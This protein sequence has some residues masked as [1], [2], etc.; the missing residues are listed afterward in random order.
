[1]SIFEL[2]MHAPGMY[3]C[4][5]CAFFCHFLLVNFNFC[6]HSGSYFHY[7]YSSV[8]YYVWLIGQRS[9][10]WMDSQSWAQYWQ[11]RS[12]LSFKKSCETRGCGFVQMY[13]RFYFEMQMMILEISNHNLKLKIQFSEHYF[14]HDWW[15]F[16]RC[17]WIELFYS[18]FASWRSRVLLQ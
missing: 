9:C 3:F 1:M 8:D 15:V 14:P 5:S 13:M 12:L 16:V 17:N 11:Q 10:G 6:S 4:N 7:V 2:Y 18:S